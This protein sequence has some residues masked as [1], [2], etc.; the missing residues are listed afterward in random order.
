MRGLDLFF[1]Q[2]MLRL[3]QKIKFTLPLDKIKETIQKLEQ[4]KESYNP[5]G[6]QAIGV[7]ISCFGRS[8]DVPLASK[9]LQINNPL[10]IKGFDSDEETLEM[11]VGLMK[12][13][14]YRNP[15][16]HPEFSEREQLVKIRNTAISCL[17]M[18]S[19]MV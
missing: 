13:Q 6:L 4:Y 5:A 10:S 18:L 11:A 9:K 7:L 2:Y 16:I 15:Y 8:Y 1:Q 14:Y 17:K 12:L 3:G 19:Q